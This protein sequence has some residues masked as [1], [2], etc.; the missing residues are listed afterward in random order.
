MT[1]TGRLEAEVRGAVREVL[2]EALAEVLARPVA[3]AEA[4]RFAEGA[5]GAFRLVRRFPL[6][7]RRDG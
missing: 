4:C 3:V 1:L 7:G 2:E 5:D 6:G